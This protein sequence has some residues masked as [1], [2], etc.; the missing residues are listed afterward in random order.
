MKKMYL[1]AIIALVSSFALFSNKGA[2]G[3]PMTY[4]K[5]ILENN[6]TSVNISKVES[7]SK[8]IQTGNENIEIGAKSYL[9]IDRETGAPMLNKN[10]SEKRPIASITKLVTALVALDNAKLEDVVEIKSS[11]PDLPAPK[12]GL[13]YSE[14]ISLENILNGLLISSDNDAAEAIAEYIGKGNYKKFVSLMND[15][16][17]EIGMKDSHFSNAVGL[18]N[19]ENYSTA[20]DLGLLA[21]TALEN[22]FIR[23]LAQTQEKR[24]KNVG[25][26][27]THYL[28]ATD[29]LLGDKDVLV[30]GLKTGE[31]PLAGGCLISYAKTKSGHEIVTIVLGSSDRFGETKKLIAWT[32]KN[33]SWK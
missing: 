22:S 25:G 9:V 15:K 30:Y 28:K 12:M 21:N 1:L 33:I 16:A 5:S 10:A 27:I 19:P 4:G 23:E 17:A 20:W 8:P 13:F 24:V 6:N 11:Y 31:T 18:D 3:A 7:V 32:E 29:E 14:K 26:D 2:I